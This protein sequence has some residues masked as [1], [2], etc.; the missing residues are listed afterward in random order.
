MKHILTLL[1]LL[2]FTTTSFAQKLVVS[3]ATLNYGDSERACIQVILE[4]DT[5][6]IKSHFKDWLKDKH[7]IRLRGFGFLT[8]KDV[9]SAEKETIPNVS[10]KQLDF[11]VQVVEE[12]QYSKMCVFGSFGYSIHISSQAYSKEYKALKS[13]T[14]DFL[15]DFVPSWYK[16]RIEEAREAAEELAKERSNLQEDIQDNEEE[17]EELEEENIEKT[18]RLKENKIDL[19]KTNQKI[20]TNKQKLEEVEEKLKQNNTNKKDNEF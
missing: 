3:D 4:P 11:Y 12:G 1:L 9:L 6:A 19:K 8:N 10:T 17:I 15:S 2:A 14:L 7:D 18:N 13:L 20:E 5:K 16:N